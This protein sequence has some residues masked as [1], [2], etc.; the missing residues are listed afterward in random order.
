MPDQ[1]DE[2][3]S[4]GRR[5]VE[6][7]SPETEALVRRSGTAVVGLGSVEQHGP[8]LPNGTDIMAA[9]LVADAVA[10]RLDALRVPFAPYGVTPLHAGWPGTISLRQET[11]D[12]LL[13]DI[14]RELI[15]HGVHTVV[16]VNWHEGNI[17]SMNAVAIRLQAE[18]DTTFVAVQAC[19]VAQRIYRELGGELTHGGGIETLAVLAHDPALAK[20]DRAGQP[21]RPPGAAELDQMRRSHEVYGFVTDVA[22]LTEAGWYGNPDWA[23]AGLAKSFAGTVAAEVVSQVQAVVRA[24]QGTEQK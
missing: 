21:S 13:T 16:L 19:Y 20:V 22:E 12:A 7:T 14:C 1:H 17:P 10:E 11:F 23:D 5:L 8:H 3:A 2:L 6:L 15:G 9:N 24:R 4:A 18:H